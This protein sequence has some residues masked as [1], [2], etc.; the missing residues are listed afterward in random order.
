[1]E[2]KSS[3]NQTLYKTDLLFWI[4]IALAAAAVIAGQERLWFKKIHERRWGWS[5]FFLKSAPLPRGGL[6][7]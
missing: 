1:L 7:A 5:A 4:L 6:L 3:K 2:T